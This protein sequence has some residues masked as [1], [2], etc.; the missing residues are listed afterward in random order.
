MVWGFARGG[1]KPAARVSRNG[2]MPIVSDSRHALRML[3]RSPWFATAAIVCLALGTGATTTV[4]AVVNT[5]LLRPLP[6]AHPDDLVMVGSISTGMN[7]P[8]DNSYLNYLDVKNVLGTAVAWSTDG[9]SI[10]L[11]DR[12][13]RRLIQAVSD[14][15]WDAL[16]V[17]PAV[18]RTFTSQ[19]ALART[20][21]I[22]VSY[23]YWQGQLNAD[24]NVVGRALVVDGSPLTIVGVAPRSFV[25]AQSLIVPDG[26]V[27]VSV[28]EPEM[29]ERRGG[30]G[31]KIMGRLKG[32]Q[33]VEAARSALDVLAAHLQ[34]QYPVENE[35]TRFVIE[36][37][38]RAR[39]DLALTGLIPRAALVFVGLTTLVLLI[40]CANVASLML[41]RAS[42]R[43]TELAVR[44]ALGASPG[45]IAAQL[46]TESLVLA[47]LGGVVGI[48]L[49]IGAAH[50]LSGLHLSSTVPVVFDVRVDWRVIASTAGAVALAAILSGAGPA[51]RSAD[52]RLSESLK[53]GGRGGAGS[54]RQRFHATLVAGQVAV[55]FVLLVAAGLFLRSVERARLLDL[56]FRQDHGFMATVDVSLGHYD[57]AKGRQF[58]R[59]LLDDMR[60]V[61]G[62]RA[63]ALAS[64]VPLGTSHRN[65]DLYAD[66]PTL[67][68]EHGHT[69]IEIVS[70]TPSYF[71]TLGIRLE[72][73]RDFTERDDSTAPP[74]AIINAATAARLWPNEDAIGR[75]FRLGP[76]EPE[77][78][79]VGV[80]A[81]VMAQF[82]NEHPHPM[83]YVPFA[84]HYRPDMTLHL[85]TRGDPSQFAAPVRAVV[86]S[87]DAN[88]APYAMTTVADHLD[89]GLAFTPIRLAATLAI[90]IGLLGLAQSL[91][92]LYGVVAYSVAQRTR[93][94]GIRMA[95][96]ATSGAIL[97][98]VLREGMLL[99]A[100]GLVVGFVI[101]LLVTGVLRSLLIGVGTHDPVTFGALAALLA[102]VTLIACWIP[103][104]R[105]ARVSPAGAMRS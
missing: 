35:G 82:V 33:S 22:V 103:A 24:P 30:G 17:R 95:I 90:A 81:T 74:V 78:Q 102:A 105:A 6:V 46:L 84:Q 85:E 66:I 97:R 8:G 15:Y 89:T 4:V 87:L 43:R 63:A 19:D 75:R 23:R 98:G 55:S 86:A 1:L 51:I 101:S 62:V 67:N 3:R 44:G 10:R 28:L 36:R 37:E 25:G 56:G 99:T 47:V 16:G 58:Y 71:E 13:D 54:S 96:G 41:A 7:L 26:W 12:S 34:H 27:P 38:L 83:L 57:E 93:E 53:D 64:T 49:A 14:N 18:G 60:R 88:L 5:L 29:L 100:V 79:V 52:P 76:A 20:P 32:G 65:V 45:R 68:N 91:I 21:L 104:Q 92:G 42:A 50:W 77:I 48:A 72:Q 2:E 9:V 59:A 94:I 69:H 61:S 11:G 39:P 40:A 80:A 70:V 31:F 73:G